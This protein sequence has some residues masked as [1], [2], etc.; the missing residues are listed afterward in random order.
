[1]LTFCVL[2][3]VDGQ[4]ETASASR[5]KT[6]NTTSDANVKIGN[7]HSGRHF[8]GKIDEVRIWSKARTQAEIQTD[9]NTTVIETESYL[10]AYYRFD[11]S[12]GTELIDLTA[13]DRDGMINGGPTWT[14]SGVA[15]E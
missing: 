7:D 6:I 2:L 13:N 5:S 15:V 9:M 10:E 1:M 11:Q 8:N 12:D 4:L 14:T 3:Y